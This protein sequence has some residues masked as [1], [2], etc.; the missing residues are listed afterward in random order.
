MTIVRQAHVGV[1]LLVLAAAVTL[2]LGARL[3]FARDRAT[4]IGTGVVVIDTNL[5]YQ[6]GAAAGTGIV[7]TSSGEVLT[8]NHVIDGATTIKVVVPNT[9][10]SYTA[11][12]VGYDRG[13]DVAVLQLVHGSNL[14]TMSPSITSKL[15][16]GTAVTAVG[17]AGGTGSLRSVTGRI[18]GTGKTITASDDQGSSEQLTGLIEM[19]AAVEP[20]DSGGPL[21]NSSGRVI[22]MDTAA[23][24]GGYGF[25]SVA[26][27]DAYAI[28]IGTALTIAR[29][30][31]TGKATPAVHIGPTAF[32]G[33][34]VESAAAD[35]Y[36]YGSGG[37]D[38]SAASGALIAGVVS[39][40]PADSA[41]LGAGDLVNAIDGRAVSSPGAVT[42]IVLSKKPG[43]KL[44]VRYTDRYGAAH[45]TSVTLVNGPPQ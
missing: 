29:Q 8:N 40:G 4:P 41:G 30:I 21:L 2:G 34:E 27:S 17:N 6:D 42:A 32:L 25:Q 18:T 13:R 43:E 5:A 33:V 22:G 20:G 16:V 24:T 37:Y 45:T 28:P 9:G 11:D 31:E 19:N 23:S 15:S 36:G 10:H 39:G 1:L 44:S 3:A 12:V 26:A 14:K 7:L 38:S 35:S